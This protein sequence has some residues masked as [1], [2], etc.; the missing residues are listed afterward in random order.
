M[1]TILAILIALTCSVASADYTVCRNGVCTVVRTPVRNAYSGVQA[2]SAQRFAN[3]TY[4]APSVSYGSA[5][6]SGY[7]S[8]GGTN[9]VSYGETYAPAPAAT[10]PASA[11]SDDLADRVSEL[12]AEVKALRVLVRQVGDGLLGSAKITHSCPCGDNCK[13]DPCLCDLTS[14]R[15][16]RTPVVDLADA[17]VERVPLNLV[18]VR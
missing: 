3:R 4:A 1:K 5:G 6:S 10:P 11:A 2:R 9:S 16:E 14:A 18:A 17:R 7:G 13:C 12:E 8:A 15:V